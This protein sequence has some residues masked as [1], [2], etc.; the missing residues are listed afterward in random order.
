[1]VSKVKNIFT[2]LLNKCSNSIKSI[3][4]FKGQHGQDIWVIFDIMKLKR[5]GF[6]I[7]LA[8][9]DGITNS[10]TFVLEKWFG[11]KGICIEPNPNYFEKLSKL[12]KCII[13]TT[14]ISDKREVV[15][16]RID[17][18]QHGGI[19]SDDT[20]NK[21]S[22]FIKKTQTIINM[23]AKPLSDVLI[24]HNAPLVIDYFS[25]DIEGAEDRVVR[26]IDFSKYKFRCM[27]IENPSSETKSLLLE[28]G[29]LLV[30]E[31]NGDGFYIHQSLKR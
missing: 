19:V 3:N 13:D 26:S 10:N 18:G 2:I 23:D 11:W 15:T 12:R 17:N 16:F 24:K 14:V 9:A 8:A 4:P 22:K 21:P 29:Y 20:K 1:V 6:F 5:G 30:K 27:T 28:A 25:L 7:D 31:Q